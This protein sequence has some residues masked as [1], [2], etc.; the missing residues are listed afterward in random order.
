M[1]P[2]ED[3]GGTRLKG[4][5]ESGSQNRLE[6]VKESEE[7]LV[8]GVDDAKIELKMNSPVKQSYARVVQSVPRLTEH[9]VEVE[10]IEGK[11]Q[12]IVPD[13]VI[14]ESVPL[15]DDL[16]VGRFLAPAPHIGRV[17]I[18][19]NKIWSLGDRNIKIDAYEMNN[20][21]VKFRIKDKATRERVLRRGMWSVA[22]IPMVVT[23]WAPVVEEEPEPE[24][25]TIPMWVTLKN[26]PH[27]MFS[28]EGLGFIASAVGKPKRL[29]PDTLLCKSF[30]EAKVFVEAEVDKGFPKSHRFT[31]KLGINAEVEFEYPWLPNRCCICS[32]WGHNPRECRATG[33]VKILKKGIN[34]EADTSQLEVTETQKGKSVEEEVHGEKQK[35]KENETEIDSAKSPR[36]IEK[37]NGNRKYTY[38]T[39]TKGG[40]SSWSE[41]SPSKAGRMEIKQASMS[42][43]STS[44]RFAILDDEKEEKEKRKISEKEEIEDYEEDKESVEEDSERE[45][46][47]IL[48]EK[49]DYKE[50]GSHKS[51]KSGRKQRERNRLTKQAAESPVVASVASVAKKQPKAAVGKRKA[52]KKK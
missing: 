17:H 19:V 40:S 38:L 6:K 22:N 10:I 32:K 18:I 45:E 7:K 30:E 41:V 27:R 12:V 16:I 4:D 5:R 26:V 2:M 14:Q 50:A 31:S 33:T 35:E 9:D 8:L 37:E 20:T 11:E 28:W 13:Q 42:A 3:P 43:I 34:Q 1:T 15:W 52:Y 49:H 46:G 23:K 39:A 25:K 51:G 47:E 21:M 29:H 24:I 44:S 36:S 48:L